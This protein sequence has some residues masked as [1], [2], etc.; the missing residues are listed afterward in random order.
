[1]KR[2]FLT[3]IYCCILATVAS[4]C[5]K[6]TDVPEPDSSNEAC[7]LQLIETTLKLAPGETKKIPLKAKLTSES[8]FKTYY[9]QNNV[10][11][12]KA[13][14]AD[15]SLISINEGRVTSLGPI[16]QT[17]ITITPENGDPVKLTVVVDY[18]SYRKVYNKDMQ[19]TA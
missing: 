7:E 9:W 18:L 4:A 13:K 16:G 8:N 12:L 1:M 5:S 15:P 10:Y 11:G 19:I 17:E 14:A 3:F 2:I 6:N